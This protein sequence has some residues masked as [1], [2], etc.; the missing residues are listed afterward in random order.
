MTPCLIDNAEGVTAADWFQVGGTLIAALIG[1][2]ALAIVLWVERR[3]KYRSGLDA[4]LAD[5]MRACAAYALELNEWQRSRNLALSKW[6]AA[7]PPSDI[8]FQT[9]IDIAVMSATK[10]RD[11]KVLQR[12]ADTTFNVK[13]TNESWLAAHLGEL[14]ASIRKWRGTG[15][16]R[17]LY[18]TLDRFDEAVIPFDSS[19]T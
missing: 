3:D 19:K 8:R 4:A 16:S 13:R 6:W 2:A 11:K 14:A 7:L 17:E 1:V 15:D 12:L 5:V 9:V 18:A 10:T